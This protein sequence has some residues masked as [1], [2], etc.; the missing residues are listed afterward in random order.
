MEHSVE[1]LTGAQ[2]V[3]EGNNSWAQE[4]DTDLTNENFSDCRF[5]SDKKLDM[6]CK[7][8]DEPICERCAYLNHKD[9]H[10][11][12][13]LIEVIAERIVQTIVNKDILMHQIL[14][15]YE[16]E[17][18]RM[19]SDYRD[20]R[21]KY[22]AVRDIIKAT[23][24]R[25]HR[26]ID[27]VV[28]HILQDLHEMENEH[29]QRFDEEKKKVD[30]ISDEIQ[31]MINKSTDLLR[32]PLEL[33][34]EN[35]PKVEKFKMFP[36]ISLFHPPSFSEGKLQNMTDR[37][38]IDNR[39]VYSPSYQLPLR[40]AYDKSCLC[41]AELKRLREKISDP[42]EIQTGIA[43]RPNISNSSVDHGNISDIMALSSDKAL[44][45]NMG[46]VLQVD[47]NGNIQRSEDCAGIQFLTLGNG[48][49][50]YFTVSTGKKIGKVD[51]RIND[52]ST[53]TTNPLLVD[54]EWTP[55][56]IAVT[57]DGNILVCCQNQTHGK[58]VKFNENLEKLSEFES[59]CQSEPHFEKPKM[60]V[61][62]RNGDI[63]VTDMAAKPSVVI[64]KE[65][66]TLRKRY[67]PD[68]PSNSF[69]EIF[70]T[71]RPFSPGGICTDRMGH[72]L[73]SDTPHRVIHILD[74]WGEFLQ[75]LLRNSLEDPRALSVDTA[76]QLWIV[77]RQKNLKVVQY[78]LGC[79]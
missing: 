75:L 70:T 18:K 4:Q 68:I 16:E 3:V 17:T 59:A 77:E 29:M 65:D 39:I 49:H 1:T 40:A 78:L 61:E 7:T 27:E 42:H 32:N 53:C 9:K 19:R 12:V 56:G 13:D 60:V 2:F 38:S 76:G 33:N 34:E 30:E 15:V 45:A 48:G 79:P 10:K 41:L 55:F 74:Q 46:K 5:H 69:T 57:K 73:I 25:W 6:F 14:P 26:E 22:S 52:T 71:R 62:N 72:I 66:G 36:K 54:E 28:H 51:F 11:V 8:C 23:A 37:V 58:V 47:N 50:L 21:G 35:M 24:A 67:Q 64:L 43:S 63:C 31:S 44:L 20:V